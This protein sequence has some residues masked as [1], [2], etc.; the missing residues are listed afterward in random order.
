[1]LSI[2]SGPQLQPGSITG[3]G[4]PYFAKIV[5]GEF[6]AESIPNDSMSIIHVEDLAK[7]H[8]AAAETATAC[9]RYF[10]VNQSWHWEDIYASIKKEYA[11]FKIPPKKYTEKNPVT[12]FDNSRRD[13]LGVT[14]KSLD[15]IFSSTLNFLKERKEI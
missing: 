1:H 12:C 8:I 14:L 11:G 7:L 2:F 10:G 3:N 15:Y 5:K 9:G 6:M 4:L 13:S